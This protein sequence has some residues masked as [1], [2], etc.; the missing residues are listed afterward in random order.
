VKWN[1]CA[2]H[3]LV[4]C[5]ITARCL[6]GYFDILLC[7]QANACFNGTGHLWHHL[8]WKYQFHVTRM[9]QIVDPSIAVD[10]IKYVITLQLDN[11]TFTLPRSDY[12]VWH[13]NDDADIELAP[14]EIKRINWL[15]ADVP[16]ENS[17]PINVSN[18]ICLCE[19]LRNFKL[20]LYSRHRRTNSQIFAY[21]KSSIHP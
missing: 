16:V 12:H 11:A 4:D 20:Q 6:V 17:F 3:L 2:H 18:R 1:A 13:M 7:A 9:T 19:N 8:S 10:I 5:S 21:N 14:F 15:S